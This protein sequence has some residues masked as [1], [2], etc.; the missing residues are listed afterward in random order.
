[1]QVQPVPPSHIRHQVL[2]EV[3]ETSRVAGQRERWLA[4]EGW[5]RGPMRADR[6]PSSRNWN[7]QHLGAPL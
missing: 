2:Q 5:P 1:M 7:P 4:Q 3:A 6:V